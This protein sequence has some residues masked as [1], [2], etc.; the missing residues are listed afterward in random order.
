MTQ[1]LPLSVFWW[2]ERDKIHALAVQTLRDNDD[3]S[4][5]FE[6]DL[7]FPQQIISGA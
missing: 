7:D 3:M 5:I 1:T 4:Y 6:G 2:L